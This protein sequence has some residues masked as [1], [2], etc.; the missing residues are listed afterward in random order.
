M[1]IALSALVLILLLLPGFI[2][3]LALFLPTW[4]GAIRTRSIPEE[5]AIAVG[6]A[7]FLHAVGAEVIALF[8]GQIDWRLW[9]HLMGFASASE[10]PLER[11][12]QSIDRDLLTVIGYLAV[13]VL[14]GGVCGL[15]VF[16]LVRCLR[17]DLCFDFFR[18]L[19][20]WD[21]LFRGEY[22]F[23]ADSS[24]SFWQRLR[25]W[26]DLAQGQFRI[27][28]PEVVWV[29]VV[30]DHGAAS[31]LYYGRLQNFYFTNEAKIDKIILSKTYRRRLERDV[32]GLETSTP[33]ELQPS[34]PEN[35]ALSSRPGDSASATAPRFY[36]ITGNFFVI[37]GEEMRTLNLRYQMFVDDASETMDDSPSS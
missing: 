35:P 12:V 21:Y 8:G 7:T 16:R 32:P 13:Q 9:L 17:L 24:A 23:V 6:F 11:L 1:S 15:T 36:P 4:R 33:G 37:H 29:A 14:V 22:Y 2:F 34:V 30:V 25:Y 31:Y 27:E 26:T 18:L 28:L 5:A 20:P 19:G 3:R 10:P